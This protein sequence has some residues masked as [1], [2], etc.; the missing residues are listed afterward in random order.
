MSKL[1]FNLRILKS[2]V[3]YGANASGKSKFIDALAF[4]KHFVITSA[5]DS[6]KGDKISVEPFRLNVE[7]E[8]EPSEFEIIFI[9][10]NIY[11]VVI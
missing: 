11:H 1:N 10:K 7:S 3:I 5:K 9:F 8:K 2:A 6:Q 4:M